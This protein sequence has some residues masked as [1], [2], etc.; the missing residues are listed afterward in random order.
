MAVFILKYYFLIT[1]DSHIL[2]FYS[3]YCDDLDVFE[4]LSAGDA[5]VVTSDAFQ[6]RFETSTASFSRRND[7]A[8]A[9]TLRINTGKRECV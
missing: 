6:R 5:Y 2:H 9:L 3:T 1:H 8:S 4:R 7:N